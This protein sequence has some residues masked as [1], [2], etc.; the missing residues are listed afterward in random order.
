[1][2]RKDLDILKFIGIICIILAHV[3]PPD[4]LFQ[5]R[6]FDVILLLIV[7]AILYFLKN[8]NSSYFNYF[9]KRIK[10]ILIPTYIFFI[11]FFTIFYF[12]KPTFFNMHSI[13]DYLLKISDIYRL[14]NFDYLWIVRIYLIMALLLPLIKKMLN[15]IGFNTTLFITILL[16]IFY[17]ILCEKKVF[18]NYFLYR[19]FAYIIPCILLIVISYWIK[20]ASNIKLFSFSIINIIIY[21][22]ILGHY[23]LKYFKFL[24]T[25][26][27]KKP[28]RIYYLSYALGVSTL[29]ILIFRNKKLQ[30]KLHTKFVEFVSR[31]SFTIYLW[32][33]F[34]LYIVFIYL[35]DINWFCKFIY[36]FS[37]SILITYIQN[38]TIRYL[39]KKN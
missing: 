15:K 31:N 22:F 27:A 24:D 4:L 29:L 13:Y 11:L 37:S 9:K 12:L 20:N 25:N 14:K 3:S 39:N 16:Y 17:E 28:F 2:R 8:D 18:D 5:I 33:I 26:I 10:T 34:F 35:N 19:W 6:N 23:Y 21:N 7:S 1:M 30:N 38:E 36:I 32:H